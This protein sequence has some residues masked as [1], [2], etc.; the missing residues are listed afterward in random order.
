M[1]SSEERSNMAE[2]T[3]QPQE[4]ANLTTP[5]PP[6]TTPQPQYTDQGAT[7]QPQTSPTTSNPP[8]TELPKTASSTPLIALMGML[9]FGA[10]FG[11]WI[12]AKRIS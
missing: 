1:N 6:E 8:A 9:S 12:L 2:N 3:Q 10:A 4:E 7:A 11:L 5:P